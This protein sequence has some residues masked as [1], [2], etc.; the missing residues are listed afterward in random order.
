[1]ELKIEINKYS[2]AEVALLGVFAFGLLLSFLLVSSRKNIPLSPPI[3]APFDGLR[4]SMPSGRGWETLDK[5]IYSDREGAFVLVSSL[6]ESYMNAATVSW[7]YYMSPREMNLDQVINHKINDSGFIKVRKSE[8]EIGEL[9][10]SVLIFTSPVG[11]S[12][13]GVEDYYFAVCELPIGRLLTL[14][15]RTIGDSELAQRTFNAAI[16]GFNFTAD[17]PPPAK[18]GITFKVTETQVGWAADM[19]KNTRKDSKWNQKFTTA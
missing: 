6:K 11:K 2:P 18:D 1:M 15:I 3:I 8:T 4:I 10:F 12:S 7:K 17:W 5:W 16:K 9:D 19:Q 14:E 13:E